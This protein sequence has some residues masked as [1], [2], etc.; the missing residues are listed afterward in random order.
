VRY[1]SGQLHVKNMN[2]GIWELTKSG[3][4]LGQANDSG[5]LL[6]EYG[7]NLYTPLRYVNPETEGEGKHFLLLANPLKIKAHRK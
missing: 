6:D 5:S 7:V 3:A 1:F 4:A 2:G